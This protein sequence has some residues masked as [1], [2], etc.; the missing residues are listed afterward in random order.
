MN[1]VLLLRELVSKNCLL[2]FHSEYYE[3]KMASA[4][5]TVSV[6]KIMGLLKASCREQRIPFGKCKKIMT[7]L[8]A[9]IT[10]LRE[11]PSWN[12]RG[13]MGGLKRQFGGSLPYCEEIEQIRAELTAIEEEV[14]ASRPSVP[15]TGA[16]GPARRH[17]GKAPRHQHQQAPEGFIMMMVPHDMVSAVLKK[18]GSISSAPAPAPA[19]TTRPRTGPPRPLAVINKH[20]SRPSRPTARPDTKAMSVEE[21]HAHSA[22]LTNPTTIYLPTVR[23][24]SQ[25]A[26]ILPIRKQLLKK[27]IRVSDHPKQF[28]YACANKHRNAQIEVTIDAEMDSEIYRTLTQQGISVTSTASVAGD[29]DEL[30]DGLSGLTINADSANQADWS[31]VG[32]EEEGYTPRTPTTPATGGVTP[33]PYEEEDEEDEDEQT[34]DLGMDFHGHAFI[35]DEGVLYEGKE[36]KVVSL[37][38]SGVCLRNATTM[39]TVAGADIEKIEKI[40]GEDEE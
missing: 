16:G 36:W 28:R 24:P 4:T 39:I 38:T 10:F 5:A 29:V 26:T 8:D 23:S 35:I 40:A 14:T 2:R 21:R 32:E 7:W 9:Q 30:A 13:V 11:R 3:N 22:S 17:A 34:P 37:G 31:K 18:G 15:A 20:A 27:G 1:L 12:V 19:R 25:N 33:Q 6:D